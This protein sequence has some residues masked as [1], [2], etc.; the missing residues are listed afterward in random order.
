MC[1]FSCYFKR[2]TTTI[3]RV[4]GYSLAPDFVTGF[5]TRSGDIDDGA[6]QHVA[7]LGRENQWQIRTGCKIHEIGI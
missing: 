4:G 7:A 5:E 6:T 3:V 2:L 1:S